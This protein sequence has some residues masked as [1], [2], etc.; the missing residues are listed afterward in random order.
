MKNILDLRKKIT[1]RVF[2][3][4]RVIMK[5]R[6][7]YIELAKILTVIVIVTSIVYGISRADDE[8]ASSTP[9]TNTEVILV[10]AT[11]TI[12]ETPVVVEEAVSTTTEPTT[13]E[14]LA[15][16]TEVAATTTSSTTPTTATST[17]LFDAI[18]DTVS[19]VVDSIFGTSTPETAT[20]T[21]VIVSD[22]VIIQEEVV[23]DTGKLVT[24]SAENESTSTPITNIIATT[25]IPKIFK[26][27]EE[28]KIHINWKNNGDQPMSFHATDTNNDN[29][30]DTLEWTVPHLSTQIFE[31]IF[32]SKAFQLDADQNILADIYEQTQT[33][34]GIYTSI[35]SGQYIRATFE[36]ILNDTKD[37]TLYVKPTEVD[38]PVAIQVYPVYT[39]AEGNQTEGVRVATF[40][41]I[42]REGMYKVLLTNLE[43]PTDVFDLKITG[44]VDVDYIV[45]P[46]D[47]TTG[48][49][50]Y[51]KMDGNV[52]DSS[53]LGNNGTAVGSPTY[54]AGRVG[55]GISLDGSTQWASIAST[56]ASLDLSTFT[57]S[58]W[59]RPTGGNTGSRSIF[60]T[61]LVNN[62]KGFNILS[63]DGRVGVQ[64]MI[65]GNQQTLTNEGSLFPTNTWTHL[66]VTVS[67]STVGVYVNGIDKVVTNVWSGGVNS[68]LGTAFNIGVREDGY[69]SW[70]GILDDA[71]IYNRV[72]TEAD[73]AML[74]SYNIY[75]CQSKASGSWSSASTWNNCNGTTPQEGDSVEILTGHTVTLGAPQTVA[76]VT[77]S[78]GSTLAT[79]SYALTNT[80]DLTVDGTLSGT[81]AITLSGAANTIYGNGTISTPIVLGANYNINTTG[82]TLTLSGIIGGASYGLTTTASGTVTLSGANT[83]GGGL[84]IKAGRVNGTTNANVFGLGSITIGDSAGGNNNATLQGASSLTFANPIILASNTTGTLA[85]TNNANPETF[86]GGVIGDNNLV[87]IN[88]YGPG[89]SITF[90]GAPIVNNGNVT[91]NN[92]S[93]GTTIIQSSALNNTGTVSN[94]STGTGGLDISSIIGTN[95]TSVIQNSS[96]SLMTLSG[97]NTYT[98]GLYI[99][100]GT[101]LGTT[102]NTAYGAGSVTLGDSSGGTNN[103]TLSLGHGRTFANP[104]ILASNVTGVLSLFLTNGY[105]SAISGVV[106]GVNNLVINSASN[107]TLTLSGLSLNN[108]GTITNTS[109]GTGGV[110]ISSVISPNVTGVIQNS[111]SSTLTLSGNNTFSGAGLIIKKGTV[112]GQTSAN[113]FGAGTITLGDSAGGNNDATL[114]GG[115]GVG[116]L[117]FANQ[118]ILASNTTGLLSIGNSGG[119]RPIFSGGLTGN[120]NLTIN[121]ITTNR[122]VSFSTGI[123]NNV[124]TITNLVANTGTEVHFNSNIG[125]NVSSVIENT[126]SSTLYLTG[127]NSFYGGLIIK[128]GTVVGSSKNAFGGSGVGVIILGDSVGGNNNATLFGNA[129]DTTIANP[130]LLAST[131]TGLLTIFSGDSSFFTGG[132]TGTNN[133][134]I[135]SGRTNRNVTFSNGIINNVGTITFLGS[136]TTC[137]IY[138][139]SVIGP[140]VIGIIQ[141]SATS[142]LILSGANTYTGLT[143]ITAGT[144]KLGAHNSLP[145]STTIKV[146][147]TGSTFDLA[148]YNQTVASINDN[149]TSTG[150]LT[151]SGATS[152]LTLAHTS[153]AS[154][155]GTISGALALTKTGANKLRLSG[156]KS[157]TGGLTIKAGIVDGEN[158]FGNGSITIGD[159]SGGNNNATLL[160][161]ASIS[162]P[163]ILASS[164]TGVLSIKTRNGSWPSLSG[165]VT[166][167][168]N[169]V[170]NS[171]DGQGGR[172]TFSTGLIN[173]SGTITNSSGNT[174]VVINAV[175]GS[176]VTGMIQ[177]SAS[178]TLTLSGNNTFS[179]GLTILKGTVIG[180]TSANA[181]GT[182]IIRLGDTSGSAGATLTVGD[183]TT[184]FANPIVLGGTSGTLTIG[185]IGGYPTGFSGGV[186]GNNNFNFNNTNIY[187]SGLYF[188]GGSI[189]NTGMVTNLS[190]GSN[191]PVNIYSVLG[192]NVTAL[193]QNS[194]TSRLTLSGNNSTVGSVTIATGTL[195]L[196][197]TTNLNVSGNWSNSGTFTSNNGTVTFTGASSTITAGS[198]PF[199]TL[200][201]SGTNGVYTLSEN[202]TATTTNITSTGITLEGAGNTL[203]SNITTGT[204]GV[205]LSHITVT[206]AVSTTGSNPLTVTNASNLTGTISVTGPL[207]GD[208]SSSLGN[209]TI[210][211]GG[212][213]AVNSVNFIGNVTNSGTLNTGNP[214][215][216][217]LTN[218]ATINGPITFNAS[219]TNV[220]TVNGNAIF[221]DSSTN[222][223]GFTSGTVTGSAT[224]NT[225]T[226]TSGAV[227][228]PDT[229][230]FG[231]TGY[232]LGSLFASS[233]EPISLW[234]FNASSTNTGLTKGNAVF[235][236]TSSNTGTI[237]G[238]ATLN[239][240]STNTGTITGNADVNYPVTRPI[241]GTVSGQII[242]HGYPG[243]YFND[244]AEGHGVSG[245]WDDL[246]NWWTDAAFTIHSTVIPSSGDDVTVY[247]NIT[248][249]G[250]TT[251]AVANTAIFESTSSNAISL[252]AANV[253]FNASS[254]N[255]GTIHGNAVFVNEGTENTGDVTGYITRQYDAGTFTVIS[256]FTHNNLHWIVQALNGARV[257]LSG[258]IYN[259]ATNTFQALNNGLFTAWNTLFS[260]GSSGVPILTITSPTTGTNIKWAPVISWGTNATCQYKIDGG[261]YTSVN[262][263]LNGSD[264][265][266]PAATAHTIFF[267]STTG[268]NISEKSVSF[269]Y[270]NT[271]PVD[272]DCSTA[273]DEVTR[274]YYFFTAPVTGTCNITA[275]TTL[276][277]MGFTL[278]GDIDARGKTVGARG[279]DLSIKNIIVTGTT[280]TAGADG[281]EGI[282]GG[283][284]GNITV[285]SSTTGHISAMGGDPEQNG[286]DAG[287]I[288]VTY[289][290]AL[291]EGTLINA[292]GGDSTGCGYGGSGGDVSLTNTAGYVIINDKGADAIPPENCTPRGQSGRGGSV[293]T[294]GVYHPPGWTPPAPVATAATRS[295]TTL[296]S[297]AKNLTER[298]S[299]GSSTP[300]V[301][302]V[303]P[304]TQVTFKPIPVFGGTGIH[305]FS[306]ESII[307]K[308]LFAPLSFTGYPQLT[309]YLAQQGFRTQQDLFLKRDKTIPLPLP[310]LNKDIPDGLLMV[311][312][313]NTPVPLTARY[314]TQYTLVEAATVQAGSPLTISLYPTTKETVIATFNG[315]TYTFKK[316]GSTSLLSI[317]LTAP[318][319][320]GTYMLKAT[321]APLPL[322]LT[323]VKAT[324]TTK[325]PST[326][327]LLEKVKKQSVWGVL[328]MWGKPVVR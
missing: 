81:G 21:D 76:S 78:S 91:I 223:L 293:Q 71:R 216:G 87:I 188:T 37:I 123:V 55:Q 258:A 89:S 111:T 120:N 72:L 84:V 209:T 126:A 180:K 177:N 234:I 284:G 2:V 140:N 318:T 226:A 102:F 270:D 229:T 276:N 70:N 205:I 103:A 279:Y 65:A 13:N 184:V 41:L 243:L 145:A 122:S 153:D 327:T 181:F 325:A 230:A 273:L 319:T 256:D 306:F 163:I 154:F 278:T 124:G 15:T 114:L 308:F 172:I 201:L 299:F 86:S 131:T 286:G 132:V 101:V 264:I 11:T 191:S 19:S 164:T 18:I 125:S 31:I 39:D 231:G 28:N 215:S 248:N 183:Q 311:S 271:Q 36:K 58:V 4:E 167:A 118:I 290:I 158:S 275:S 189:N 146:Y 144:L 165:G 157:F 53:G 107:G 169:L 30:L 238:N 268:N 194:A 328:K 277:G 225:L 32:I 137:N 237:S 162:N 98:S 260:G 40:P 49:V 22:V 6:P 300:L 252:H 129:R 272:T 241:A 321:G 224:F 139:N 160:A 239:H 45:D 222:Y 156:S 138:I 280:T 210:S 90:S 104:I 324:Q 261:V 136:C 142:P 151:N 68:Y 52:A 60:S 304:I 74:Y 196:S 232:V 80:G 288:N 235:N 197:G 113:A 171:N 105:T 46:A 82:T 266:R 79:A 255:S 262:C 302:P 57:V 16:T 96:T 59:T 174:E 212:S 66:V 251:T 119:A 202:I 236:D 227:T 291:V 274:P 200:T 51:W 12:P 152:T 208:G 108:N 69:Q 295:G 85:I 249:T 61:G 161:H 198:S 147:G 287:T 250:T 24:L 17:S 100:K 285:A 128:S 282:D 168:N 289:S 143:T 303:A 297:I 217:K 23:T 38:Q 313:N 211:A 121:N 316:Q 298:Y 33:R 109:A 187:G 26:V 320:T 127:D 170:I 92:I 242:Y 83:F 233:S 301:I 314:S 247:G 7:W 56:S 312:A 150:T 106:T 43:I 228:F 67:S 9:V 199:N 50:G 159:S 112:V 94:V 88:V 95:V 309:S 27:G 178:S 155:M 48:L 296:A 130:I 117:I 175:V 326:P 141:N 265:P 307:G 245:K 322:S 246:N 42:D 214:V 218:T 323:A 99:S 204:N 179:S 253:T 257:D 34:D 294:V 29:Y 1:P 3:I 20:S 97:N 166:G 192:P 110:V 206:G 149:S 203:T 190:T 5:R 8:A 75:S 73:V 186:T 35:T 64:R 182:G 254:S 317:T 240:S 213:V 220:G 315:Q 292:R 54:A 176:S 133:L 62:N 259:L 195:A 310:K 148:G 193:I 173:N 267:K 134:A 221:N 283:A 269:T 263:S 47:I 305:S 244:T 115:S 135:L 14:T 44:D 116:D 281:A 93:A 207:T 10:E 185:G 63:Y 219:S 77:V 25:S